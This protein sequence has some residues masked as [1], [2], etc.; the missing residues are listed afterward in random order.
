MAKMRHGG[1]RSKENGVKTYFLN[2]ER[3]RSSR[4]NFYTLNPQKAAQAWRRLNSN[5]W[6]QQIVLLPTTLHEALR[7]T[8]KERKALERLKEQG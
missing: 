5:V 4:R 6:E 7:N 8:L 2:V 1:M 3:L